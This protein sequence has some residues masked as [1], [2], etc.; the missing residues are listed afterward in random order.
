MPLRIICVVS[1]SD[2]N[3]CSTVGSIPVHKF[4]PRTFGFH[5]ELQR[6]DSE[7]KF[8]YAYLKHV[9][10]IIIVVRTLTE[11]FVIVTI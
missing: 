10:F 9:F 5:Y 11:K 2:A 4:S 6:T 3:R 7:P 1:A 8:F